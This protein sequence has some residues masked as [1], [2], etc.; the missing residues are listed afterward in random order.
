MVLALVVVLVL[1]MMVVLEVFRLVV[2]MVALVVVLVLVLGCALFARF[3][4][5]S[6]V[7][8]RLLVLRCLCFF[9]YCLLL[10]G[11]RV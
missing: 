5:F 3:A 1:V 2:M 10:G 4:R 9:W 6:F 8:S 11:G 7:A